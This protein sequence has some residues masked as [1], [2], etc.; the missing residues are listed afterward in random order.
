[1]A[2]DLNQMFLSQMPMRVSCM[3]AAVDMDVTTGSSLATGGIVGGVMVIIGF[4]IIIAVAALI[5]IIVKR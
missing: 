2:P 3:Y 5:L 1:M 4:A